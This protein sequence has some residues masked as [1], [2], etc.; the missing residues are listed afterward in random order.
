MPNK[1]SKRLKSTISFGNCFIT[2][3]KEILN[4]IS[5]KN[6]AGTPRLQNAMIYFGKDYNN[7]IKDA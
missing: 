2:I 1:H 3:A 5:E 6:A 7:E 4:S